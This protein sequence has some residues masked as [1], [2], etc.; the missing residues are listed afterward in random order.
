MGKV[1]PRTRSTPTTAAPLVFVIAG[2]GHAGS[3]TVAKD[4]FLG[5]ETI[6]E[7]RGS[8][9]HRRRHAK[10]RS[11]SGSCSLAH[12]RRPIPSSTLTSRTASW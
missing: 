3:L 2:A 10:A 4:M 9:E 12:I 7:Q 5:D 8:K 6:H 11:C 1:A